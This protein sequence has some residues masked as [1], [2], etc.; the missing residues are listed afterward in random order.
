MTPSARSHAVGRATRTL[1]FALAGATGVALAA[2]TTLPSALGMDEATGRENLASAIAW[3]QVP[4]YWGAEAFKR[5]NLEQR[6]ALVQQTIAWA[7]GFVASPA[8]AQ[9][10]AAMREQS[11]P[12]APA[13]K[14]SV[15]DELKAQRAEQRKQIE[16]MKA[17]IKQMPPEMRKG[18]E[19][20][21][22]STEAQFAQMNADPQMQAMQRQ[23]MQMQREAEQTSYAEAKAKWQQDWPA[24]GRV[25]VARRLREFLA[26]CKDVDFAAALL[27]VDPYGKRRFALTA[28]EQKPPEWKACYRAGK[29]PTE[30]A[31][32][33]ASAWLAELPKG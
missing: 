25:L 6:V 17:S 9:A 23:G 3:G 2:A 12:E 15:D 29:A 11:A 27:P 22:K 32:A 33:A 13:A 19:E 14:G 4:L 10:Y 31:R 7:R 26:A 20:V 30:A 16:D 18:M 24:D 8:F 28:H 5:A 21:V 1:A